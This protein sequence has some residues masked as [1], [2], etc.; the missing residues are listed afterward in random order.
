[1]FSRVCRQYQVLNRVELSGAAV[2]H[3]VSLLQK[4]HPDFE[5]IPVLKSNAY[6][7]GLREMAQ[8]LNDADINLL[9]ADGYF[10]AARIRRIT[11]HRIVVLGYILP[12][13]VKLLDTKRCSFVVQDTVVLTALGKL[14]KP[15]RIHVELNTGM[16][17]LGLSRQELPDYLRVLGK[18][19]NLELEGV[20]SQQ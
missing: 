14:R 2:L 15:V 1:M 8:I 3:N 16:N 12:S 4:Q 6:G 11:Q 19:P 20:M 10:E 17:R 18:Y 13:N 5:I 9:A 7:H